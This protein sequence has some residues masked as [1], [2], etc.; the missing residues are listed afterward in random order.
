MNAINIF[1]DTEFTTLDE[2][3]HD[4]KL[5]SIGLVDESGAHAFYVELNHWSYGECSGF[6]RDIV[7]P[8]LQEGEAIM[9]R[10][11][12]GYKLKAWL[13]SFKTPVHIWTD[14]PSLDWRWLDW[15]L[16]TDTV[17][18][19]TNLSHSP[20]KF[21]YDAI[22]YCRFRN[23]IDASYS[24]GGLREHHALDDAEANRRGWLAA[25]R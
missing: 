20:S 19:P 6:T 24:Q 4:A 3:Y 13:E 22:R 11:E 5:I 1:F 25:K 7:V 14:A 15:L 18:W 2:R 17:G 21:D 23:M 10:A 9:S 16:N 12:V 8:L